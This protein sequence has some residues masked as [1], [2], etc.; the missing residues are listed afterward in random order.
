[1]IPTPKS[2]P[3]ILA[4]QFFLFYVHVLLNKLKCLIVAQDILKGIWMFKMFL[5]G[6]S[7]ILNMSRNRK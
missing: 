1:M 2:T 3:E 5:G 4:L 7:H 6:K